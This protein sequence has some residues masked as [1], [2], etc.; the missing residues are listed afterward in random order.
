VLSADAVKVRPGD[1]MRLEAWG[2]ERSLAARVRLVEPSG[3]TKL[4]ALGVEEQR[5][6]VIGDFV[7]PAGALGDGYRLE[8]SIVVWSAEDVLRA[9]TSALFRRGDAWQVF[10]VERGRA[11]LRPVE[12]GH[13][14]AEAAE[15]VAGLEPGETLVLHPSDR[16]AD[17]VRVE[18]L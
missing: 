9:P 2:G 18:P 16:V 13:R 14:G 12:V 10:V 5:V 7:D 4:S 3:Y 6:N 1:A 11:R 17:G 8:A 15:I